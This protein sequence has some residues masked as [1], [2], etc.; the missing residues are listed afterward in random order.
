MINK[1]L[2]IL[3][4]AVSA[5]NAQ[6]I[7]ENFHSDKLGADR[8]ITIIT[9]LSYEKE[10]DKKYPL[11]LVL[12]GDYLTDPVSGIF[13]YTSYWDDLPE[14]IIVGISQGDTRE[15][16]T[17][18]DKDSG[19]PVEQGAQFFDFIGTELMPHLEKKYRLAP[20]KAVA[21]H[22]MTAG[23]LNAFLFKDKPLFN[24]YIAMSPELGA[25]MEVK[26]AERL[27]A[28][29]RPVFYYLATSDSDAARFRKKIKTL[30]EG[31]RA[32][33]N[34]QVK[35][36][37]E[38]FKGAS[39]YALAAMAIP[40]AIYHIFGDFQPISNIEYQSKIV[41]LPGGYVKYLE[42]KY[43]NMEA[44][45]GTKV[46]VRLNDIQAVEAAIIKNGIFDELKDLAELADKN[47]P[48]TILPEYYK[49]LFYE[50][51]G[52]SKRAKK[53]YMNSMDLKEIGEYTREMLVEKTE[54][55]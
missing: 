10:K 14:V 19:F 2:L 49:G 31:I 28:V 23:F 40:Q 36:K 5:A 52:D 7:I 24:A 50:K 26:I 17:A 41:T 21:G 13:S 33:N 55:L 20:F 38:E 3:L 15:D 51:T 45:M 27:G 8:E 25:D 18:F 46:K 22:D 16:D 43:K 9:P 53:V 6:E 4:L 47:Y 1:Y 11:V 39:H 32:K 48:K 34:A 35:Y 29:A 30:D 12:D 54:K 37:F 42:D 44:E